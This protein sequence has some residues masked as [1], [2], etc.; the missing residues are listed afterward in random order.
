MVTVN[1]IAWCYGF[2]QEKLGWIKPEDASNDVEKKFFEVAEK[3]REI[4]CSLHG[5]SNETPWEKLLSL[6]GIWL[7]D[8]LSEEEQQERFNHTFSLKLEKKGLNSLINLKI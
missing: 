5:V 8:K 6:C 3:L 7:P 1:A 2:T 4:S